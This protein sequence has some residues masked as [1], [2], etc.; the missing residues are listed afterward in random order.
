MN[1]E[2]E[3]KRLVELMSDFYY[4]IESITREDIENIADKLLDNGI[5]VPPVKVGQT[6]FI[7]TEVSKTI[8]EVKVIGVWQSEYKYSIITEVGTIHTNSI[9]KTVFLSR[10]EA[11]KM[12]K[13]E[14][15]GK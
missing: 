8:Q 5:V 4:E 9:G 12:L 13:G 15:E 6:V 3:R 14:G 2:A 10:E 1:R 7:I 11:E